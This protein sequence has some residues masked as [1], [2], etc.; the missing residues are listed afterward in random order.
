MLGVSPEVLLQAF[1]PFYTQR[2]GGTGLGL[3]IA[4]KI[5]LDHRG[6]LW[7]LGRQSP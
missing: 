4:K 2:P 5:I 7:V 3:A 1:A 6:S